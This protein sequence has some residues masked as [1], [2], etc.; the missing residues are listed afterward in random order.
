MNTIQIQ[1]PYVIFVGDIQDRT[2]AKTG[3]GLAK[4]CADKVIGQLRLPGCQADLGITDISLEAA[5]DQGAKSL[6]IGVA[7][8]G[9]TINQN[10]LPVFVQALENG[11]DIVNGLH[12][13]L[14]KIPAIA[15]VLSRS[16]SGQVINVR[17]HTG[18]LPIGNGRKRSGKR[19]LTIGTDCAVGKKYTALALTE[20]LTQNGVAATFRATGQTGIMI[21][22][23]GLPVDSVVSDFVS[24]AAE[25][26]SP[27]N[28]ADHWDIIEGQGSLFNPSFSAVSIG[29]LHGSQP[30][31]LVLCHD[32]ARTQVSTCPDY[33]LPDLQA[34]IDLHVQCA[35]IVNPNVRCIGVSVNTSSLNLDERQAYLR[36]L[37]RQLGLPCVDPLTDGCRP[38]TLR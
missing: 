5:I 13:N 24:G 33:A 17:Q 35:R 36:N 8:V 1:W 7:T 9:G 32:A 16:G 29:L 28:D 6:V 25:L 15:E 11:L 22:G 2:L 37:E 4:W 19:L 34:C 10:W 23:E 31:A 27:D 18:E 20:E 38:S 21:A 12:T 30:D 14:S 3:Y 26:I